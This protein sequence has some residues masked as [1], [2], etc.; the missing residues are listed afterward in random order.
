MNKYEKLGFM[1]EMTKKQ[2]EFVDYLIDNNFKILNVKD[3]YVQIDI[4][5]EKDGIIETYSIPNLTQDIEF[6]INLVNKM[7]EMSKKL[8]EL[9]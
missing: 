4:K 7:F 2:E 8:K 6:H 3:T 9:E 5:L 1:K